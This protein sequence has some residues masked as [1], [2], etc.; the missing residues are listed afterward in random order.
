MS[1]VLWL[2]A[3]LVEEALFETSWSKPFKLGV[4]RVTSQDLSGSEELKNKSC[5]VWHT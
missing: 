1:I 5:T 4:G 3:H 2:Y